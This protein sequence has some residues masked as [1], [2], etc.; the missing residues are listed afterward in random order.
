MIFSSFATLVL[1][2][3]PGYTPPP[4]RIIQNGIKTWK[5][6]QIF[7]FKK[8]KTVLPIDDDIQ[9]VLE[10]IDAVYEGNDEQPEAHEHQD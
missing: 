10:R 7:F 3:F 6:L 1:S 5:N 4:R 2:L 9:N 8:K